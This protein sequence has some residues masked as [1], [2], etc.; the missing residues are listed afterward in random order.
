M[1]EEEIAEMQR[2]Y[3][4]RQLG[5]NVDRYKEPE[6]ELDSEGAYMRP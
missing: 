5:T 2:K 1:D 3:A 4:R 6:P